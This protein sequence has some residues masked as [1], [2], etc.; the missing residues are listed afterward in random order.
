M[1]CKK[2]GCNINSKNTYCLRCGYNNIDNQSA[3]FNTVTKLEQAIN[4]ELKKKQGIKTLIKIVVTTILLCFI[5]ILLGNYTKNRA[6]LYKSVNSFCPN[7]KNNIKK[8]DDG[9][10][11]SNDGN[12]YFYVFEEKEIKECEKIKELANVKNIEKSH[13]H[14][15]VEFEDNK[16]E[17]YSIIIWTRDYTLIKTQVNKKEYLKNN[18]YIDAFTNGDRAYYIDGNNNVYY[19][20]NI[21]IENSI[22]DSKITPIFMPTYSS[23]GLFINS[24]KKIYIFDKNNKLID[25][26]EKIK[27][28]KSKDIISMYKYDSLENSYYIIKNNGDV[29]KENLTFVNQST[30]DENNNTIEKIYNEV[31]SKLLILGLISLISNIIIICLSYFGKNKN[32]EHAYKSVFKIFAILMIIYYFT[33]ILFGMSVSSIFTLEF[34]TGVIGSLV[35]LLVT[36]FIISSIYYINKKINWYLM[37]LVDSNNFILFV[38]FNIL[39]SITISFIFTLIFNLFI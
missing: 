20:S 37:N 18:K 12:V 34:I 35:S 7:L 15:T 19:Y 8:F 6:S 17:N 1:I 3:S 11:L 4:P 5:L 26:K 14:L 32:F 9:L 21:A 22:F 10:F 31:K 24:D 2:C 16:T 25:S 30:V 13:A 36:P 38:I 29:Y 27:Q 28:F 33:L 39:T 23:D